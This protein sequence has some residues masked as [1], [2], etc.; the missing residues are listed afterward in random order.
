MISTQVP[1]FKV[2]SNCLGAY[3]LVSDGIRKASYQRGSGVKCLRVKKLSEV[4]LSEEI[5]YSDT[6]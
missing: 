5:E 6:K 4:S 2:G 1:A 3:Q